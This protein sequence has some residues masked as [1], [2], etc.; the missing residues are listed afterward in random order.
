MLTI[1]S[2]PLTTATLRLVT[3]RTVTGYPKR[4]T[5]RA[6]QSSCMMLVRP[7]PNH[8]LKPI[9]GIP[10]RSFISWSRISVEL[11]SFGSIGSFPFTR[12]ILALINAY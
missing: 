6:D 5:R 2:S 12:E 8:R 9:W 1:R 7:V 3:T 10:L 11:V 4:T